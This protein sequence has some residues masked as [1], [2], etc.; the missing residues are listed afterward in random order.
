[1]E[2]EKK[3]KEVVNERPQKASLPLIKEIANN[4]NR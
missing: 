2:K 3:E 4:L 1:M